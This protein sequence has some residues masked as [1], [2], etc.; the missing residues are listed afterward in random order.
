M[1]V[2]FAPSRA[3]SLSLCLLLLSAAPPLRG[4]L[5]LVSHAAW[6]QADDE[7]DEEIE[8]D[9]MEPVRQAAGAG[10]TED[11]GRASAASETQRLQRAVASGDIAA[12]RAELAKAPAVLKGNKALAQSL[13]AMALNVNKRDIAA[14]FLEH[15]ADVN[16]LGDEGTTPLAQALSNGRVETVAWLLDKK[17]DVNAVSRSGQT[18]VFMALSHAES[19]KVLLEKGASLTARN[20]KGQTPLLAAVAGGN[21]GAVRVLLAKGADIKARTEDGQTALHLAARTPSLLIKMLLQ[22]GADATA[23][24][25]RGNT[26]L[27]IALRDRALDVLEANEDSEEYYD[28]ESYEDE[29]GEIVESDKRAPGVLDDLVEKS[30]VMARNAYDQTPLLLALLNRDTE[31]R[32]L[33]LEKAPKLDRTSALFDAVSQGDLL[34]LAPL[35][36]ERPYLAFTR[37][38]NGMTPLHMAALW[39][40]R[41]ASEA[42]LAKGVDVNARDCLGA[43]PLL[44]AVSEGANARRARTLVPILLAKGAKLNLADGR[45]QTV[46]HLAVKLRDAELLAAVLNAKANLAARDKA[47]RTPLHIAVTSAKDLV[48]PLLAAGAEVNVRDF[49]G[50]TPLLL[51]AAN[52]STTDISLVNALLARGADVNARNSSGTTALAQAVSNSYDG[53]GVP[54]IRALVAA[55]ADVTVRS[56]YGDSPLA[57]AISNKELFPVL[58]GAKK[59]DVNA[60]DRNGQTL[61]MRAVQYNNADAVRALLAK[62]ADA[63]LKNSSGETALQLAEK[64]KAK[65]VIEALQAPAR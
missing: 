33:I 19:L 13:F 4:P 29:E 63:S 11:A 46:L 5:P 60:F 15:G 12:V 7:D 38:P 57:S 14:L 52:G 54:L 16:A 9:E 30:D 56:T 31:A 51:A 2:R 34:K 23:M 50:E 17:A 44:C 39:G 62:G 53:R 1:I 45:G 36:T 8:A 25:S 22:G 24:D 35:L 3:A 49:S 48:A 28:E 42:L 18:P 26:P 21:I 55:G 41:T 61:L 64:N 37:L 6:A 10:G 47:G 59:L 65:A 40:S 27:H 43:T 20:D 58:L 32:A